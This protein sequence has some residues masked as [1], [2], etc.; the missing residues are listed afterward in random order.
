MTNE[1]NTSERRAARL[2]EITRH[3]QAPGNKVVM[4]RRVVL[5]ENKETNLRVEIQD[6]EVW[7]NEAKL[8]TAR[9]TTYRDTVTG[10]PVIANVDVVEED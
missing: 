4:G 7:T 5:N 6:V 1:L 2:G 9:F 3:M 8:G 10:K